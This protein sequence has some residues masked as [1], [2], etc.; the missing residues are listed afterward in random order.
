M[1]FCTVLSKT[2]TKPSLRV[3]CLPYFIAKTLVIFEAKSEGFWTTNTEEDSEN[4]HLLSD[5]G[6]G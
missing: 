1:C 4:L 2:G 3:H 6:V 5:F